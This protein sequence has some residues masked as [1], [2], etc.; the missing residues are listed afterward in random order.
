MSES[1]KHCCAKQQGFMDERLHDG[2]Y[3]SGCGE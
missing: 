3:I 1:M 2:V